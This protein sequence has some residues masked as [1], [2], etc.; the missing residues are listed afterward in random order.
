M[1]HDEA[2]AD[3]SGQRLH[4]PPPRNRDPTVSMNDLVPIFRAD[5]VAIVAD[6]DHYYGLITRMDMINFLRHESAEV[7]SNPS[8]ETLR[9]N[10]RSN[11]TMTLTTRRSS[12]RLPLHPR[13]PSHLRRDRRGHAA[14]LHLEHLRSGITRR[15]QGLRVLAQPQPHPLQL[16]TGAGHPRRQQDSPKSDDASHGGF[17]FASGLAAAGDLPRDCSRRWRHGLLARR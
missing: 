14:D 1:V 10:H 7:P 4:D 2:N 16:R 17:A 9:S 3:S 15:P 5:R 8:T 12:L 13:R 6:A 11:H